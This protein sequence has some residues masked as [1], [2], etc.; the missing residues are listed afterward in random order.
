[1]GCITF[2]RVLFGDT[3]KLWGELKDLCANVVL[4]EE[5]DSCRWLLT[6]DGVCFVKS[7]YD[8]LKIQQVQRI[9][10]SLFKD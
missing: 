2:Q 10:S 1:M 3:A 9:G 7:L 4:S 5:K 6:K 8:F